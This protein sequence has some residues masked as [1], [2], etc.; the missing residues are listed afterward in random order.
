MAPLVVRSLALPS[1][2]A[3]EAYRQLGI[4]RRR[5]GCKMEAAD[6]FDAAEVPG[7]TALATTWRGSEALKESQMCL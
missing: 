4:K 3:S 2:V 5:W 7:W 1:R 6:R